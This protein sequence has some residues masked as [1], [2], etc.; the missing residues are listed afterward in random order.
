LGE[1]AKLMGEHRRLE[2]PLLSSAKEARVDEKETTSG[3]VK[4]RV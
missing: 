3:L 1:G 4:L 2:V